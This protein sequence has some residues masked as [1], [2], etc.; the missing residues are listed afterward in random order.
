MRHK[1]TPNLGRVIESDILRDLLYV[2]QGIDGRFL[3]YDSK[4]DAFVMDSSVKLPRPTL[5]I[6]N[7]LSELGWLYFTIQKNIKTAQPSS[8]GLVG[9]SLHSAF[10][11]EMVD[12][13]RLI[14]MLENELFSIKNRPDAFTAVG[15]SL[16]R[17]Y[18]WVLEP[19]QRLRL[20]HLLMEAAKDAKG[21]AVI[22]ILYK[23]ADHGDPYIKSFVSKLLPKVLFIWGSE[24]NLIW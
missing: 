8:L 15:L 20:I 14:A 4:V 7:K 23:Y 3:K 1:L 22:S 18:V 24:S 6:V 9:Q 19:L 5:E 16:K 12:F 10:K 17:L 11:D 13:Y 2:F 21:G